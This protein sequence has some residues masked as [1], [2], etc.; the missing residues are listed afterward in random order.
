MRLRVSIGSEQGAEKL[1]GKGQ[2]GIAFES[3]RAKLVGRLFLADGTRP[4]PTALVLHGIPGIEQNHD[5]AQAL[6]G[7]GWN[8]A[9]FHYRGCWGSKGPFRIRDMLDDVR[10]AVDHLT[11]GAVRDV[12]PTR[13]IAIGHSLGGWAAVLAAC[14][15]LRLRGVGVYGMIPDPRW[16]EDS[17][18]LIESDC[19]PWL[20]GITARDFKHEYASLDDRHSPIDRVHELA[21]RPLLVVHG[22]KDEG[23]PIA[24]AEAF[25]RRAAEPKSLAVHPEADH[26]FTWHRAWLTREIVSWT[27]RLTRG[28]TFAST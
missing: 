13:L 6:R 5:I 8:A 22:A 23:V 3:G 24:D 1:S 18:E 25:F 10:A 16:Y 4:G 7:G 21:P 2:R 28:H 15:D 14:E 11:S 26:D 27:R 12:D 20:D 17:E 19:V 9:I